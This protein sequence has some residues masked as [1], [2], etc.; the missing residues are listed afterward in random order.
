MQCLPTTQHGRPSS[1]VQAQTNVHI[2]VISLDGYGAGRRIPDI[3][4]SA[5]Q[6]FIFFVV[7]DSPMVWTQHPRS[8]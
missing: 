2:G 6:R 3:N 8:T 1:N 7:R 5:V 4:S